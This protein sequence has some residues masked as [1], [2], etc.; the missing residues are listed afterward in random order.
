MTK[1][2]LL[3]GGLW[4]ESFIDL[5][6][7]PDAGDVL[8]EDRYLFLPGGPAGNAAVAARY[9]GVSTSLCARVG[10]DGNGNRLRDFFTAGG[11]GTAHIY[12]ESS[13]QTGFAVTWNDTSQPGGDKRT[14]LCRGASA[15]ICERDVD[16]ALAEDPDGIFL[17]QGL[18]PYMV[19]HGVRMA[20]QKGIPAYLDASDPTCL[21]AL[22]GRNARV[23]MLYM[24]D[25]T[26]ESFCQMPTRDVADCLKLSLSIAQR[27]EARYYVI[28][29][30]K[31]GLF[32]YDGKQY[33]IVIGTDATEGRPRTDFADVEAAVLCTE[34]MTHGGGTE[35]FQNAAGIAII[36]D[37]LA[38]E[39]PG[40]RIP[41]RDAV[42]KYIRDHGLSLKY[43]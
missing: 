14:V 1:R 41:T 25:D 5:D 10:K 11:V 31:R 18:D 32:V 28:R 37:R 24:R 4:I 7:M 15:K 30:K 26:V 23:E 43:N 21:T 33:S 40:M 2:L 42:V 8:C 3:M 27:V 12:A 29:L 13:S 19:C 38:R 34:L 9:F 16:A 17:A 39:A 22:T 35:V 20:A 6:H 36:A